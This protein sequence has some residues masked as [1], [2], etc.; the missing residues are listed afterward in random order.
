MSVLYEAAAPGDPTH[1]Q[2]GYWV[3]HYGMQLLTA[4]AFSDPDVKIQLCQSKTFDKWLQRL[5]L[6]TSE[7]SVFF[8]SFASINDIGRPTE[9]FRGLI[10]ENLL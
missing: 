9:T 3:V 2:A 4:W 7:V 10:I 5:V 8:H 6:K 1:M